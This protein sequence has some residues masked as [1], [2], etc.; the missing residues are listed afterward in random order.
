MDLALL[1]CA[2]CAVHYI[3]WFM[4]HVNN[5]GNVYCISGCSFR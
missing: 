3:V 5:E 4:V 1:T 2:F